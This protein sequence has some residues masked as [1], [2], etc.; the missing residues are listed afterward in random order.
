MARG[1]KQKEQKCPVCD[2]SAEQGHVIYCNICERWL[3]LTC[4]DV[5]ATDPCVLN[6]EDSYECFLCRRTANGIDNNNIITENTSQSISE[7]HVNADIV[8]AA[9]D[10][11]IIDENENVIDSL[12]P[13]ISQHKSLHHHK[14]CKM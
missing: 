14:L 12:N 10:N 8:N 7:N 5:L 11:D 1:R 2:S 9:V 6:E 13:R 3:H 4:A